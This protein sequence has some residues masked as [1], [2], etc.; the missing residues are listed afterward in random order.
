[1]VRQEQE[2]VLEDVRIA[3]GDRVLAAV[4]A[5]AT[6]SGFL[7]IR[8]SKVGQLCLSYYEPQKQ[9]MMMWPSPVIVSQPGA[10]QI[11]Y[12]A[13]ARFP[14][15]RSLS[16]LEPHI[17]LLSESHSIVDIHVGK[18]TLHEGIGRASRLFRPAVPFRLRIPC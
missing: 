10:T 1:M 2:Q 8:A 18:S 5:E 7:G 6:E 12:S 9:S 14:A 17:W 4:R 11:S 16:F 15:S 3:A 13:S